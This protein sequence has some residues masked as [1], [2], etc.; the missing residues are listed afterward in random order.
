[1]L[2]VT[3]S[4]FFV[5]ILLQIYW[6][7]HH[8][9]LVKVPLRS[10]LSRRIRSLYTLVNDYVRSVLHGPAVR[11]YISMTEYGAIRSYTEKNGDCIRLLCTKSVWR[12]CFFL[13]NSLY[14]SVYDTE[15]HD[16]NKGPCKSSYFSVYGRLRACLFDLDL[17]LRWFI[18]KCYFTIHNIWK[19]KNWVRKIFLRDH[20][21]VTTCV[22]VLSYKSSSCYRSVPLIFMR[23]LY[24]F[25]LSPSW[26][27]I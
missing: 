18:F 25:S 8:R 16:R 3:I 17:L 26:L 10:F 13:P 9:R 7:P 22:S 1:M 4:F 14:F 6:L 5:L 15:K 23:S 2:M 19:P 20:W 11:S 27:R 12:A 24:I 21:S